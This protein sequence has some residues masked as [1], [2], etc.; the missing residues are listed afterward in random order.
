MNIPRFSIT[1]QPVVWVVL[2][3]VLAV[4]VHNYLTISQRED[5]EF[6]ISVALIVTIWPGASAEKVERLVTEK[7]EDKFEEMTVTKEIT[8]TT[9]ESLSVIMIK[10]DYDCDVDMAWQKLRNKIAEVSDELPDNI[11]GPDVIDD[12]GDVTAMIYTLSSATAQPSEL[13][14]WAELLKSDLKKAPSCGK[15]ELL[16]ERQEA[17]YIEGPLESFSLYQFSPLTAAKI[18]DYQNVNMMAGYARTPDRKYRMEVSGSFKLTEQLEN[19]ILD[20]SRKSGT[21]LKVKDVF[22]VRRAYKEPPLDFMRSN[23]LPAIGLDIRMKKGRN[24]V[25]LGEEIKAIGEQF[26]PRLPPNIKMEL[27]HDQP[28]QVGTFVD[29]F[30]NN[31]FEGLFI[32]IIVMFL[33]MGLRSAAII[34]ISLPLSIVMAFALMPRFDVDLETVSIAA[35]I[36]ALGMLVDN[37]IIITDNIDVYL[38][39]GMNRLEAAIKGAQELAI[40]ALSGTLATVLAFI[41][42]ILMSDESGDYIRS[43]PIV[44]SLSLLASLVLAVTV[45]PITSYLFLRRNKKVETD[46]AKAESRFVRFYRSM[47]TWSLRHRF[48]MIVLTGAV[49]TGSLF[50]LQSIGFS[51]FPE[52]QR[53]QFMIDIWLPEGASLQHTTEVA[54]EVEA[55]LEQDEHIRNYVSYVGKG[56]PRFYMSIKPEFNATNFAQIIVTTTDAMKTRS[57]VDHLNERFPQDIS[58]ARAIASNL[59]MGVPVEAPIAMRVTGPDLAIMKEISDQIQDVLRSIDGTEHVRDNVG[60]P[61]PNLA[62]NVDNESALMA[63]ITNTEVAVSL[64]TA[65]EGLPITSFREGDEEVPVYMRLIESERNMGNTLDQI[66]VPSQTTGEKVPLTTFASIETVW[67]PGVIKRTDGKRSITALANIKGRLAS[68]ILKEAWPRIDAIDLPAGYEIESVGEEKERNKSFGEMIVIFSLIIAL[69]LLMLVIQFNSI[70]KALV[71]LTSVPLAIIG[72]VFG[73]FI[74]GN[75][76]A[77]MP[78]LGVISL[79]G[80]V[81]K[82][83]VV[84]MEFVNQSVAEG[85]SLDLAIIEAGRQRLR[86]IILTAATTIGGLIPLALFGGSLWE[87]MAYAMIFGLALATVLTLVVV[88]VIYYAV[89]RKAEA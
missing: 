3:L 87:G 12:F 80:M 26:A 41:P 77:F 37:A 50:L 48:V 81:I 18:L 58:G 75:S 6:K 11:I 69:I 17:I 70:K 28:R 76:F 54:E 84:W 20:V 61:V 25:E 89:F 10:V 42:L 38:Q 24:L 31:L 16:G 43:L 67:G 1:H 65:Y 83:A 2:F 85:N 73:L 66:R 52:A 4:G 63:G 34:A 36:I 45:T 68:D 55:M 79:A 49:L 8:S 23:G 71:I 13:K 40:P 44:V 59:W 5:P 86:P 82:N 7:L 29:T 53:D 39:R 9:R 33:A 60:M 56:G 62:V 19:A 46:T 35:F 27:V 74:S 78:F 32:V 51:F 15:I 30:M 57:I 22:S 14:Q 47:M 88:P 64:L 72:A 21:P